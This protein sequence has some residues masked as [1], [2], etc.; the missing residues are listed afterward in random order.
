[1]I[2]KS[3]SDSDGDCFARMP[4][5]CKALSKVERTCGTYKCPFYKPKGCKE[6]IKLG[7]GTHIHMLT[8]T[9]V[10]YRHAD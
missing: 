6:W 2:I 10:E 1:M 3:R 9:E 4:N 7:H 8:P 5:G